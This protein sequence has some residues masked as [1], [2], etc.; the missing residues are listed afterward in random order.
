MRADTRI[1]AWED[2]GD[3]TA[4]L[5]LETSPF[6]AEGGGQVSDIGEI[7]GAGGRAAVVD[8]FRLGSDQVLRARLTEGVLGAGSEVVATVDVPRRRQIQANHTATHVLNWALRGT[9]GDGV[10]QAGSYVGPDKLRFDFTHRGRVE[11]EQLER[12]EAMVNGRVAEDQ[13]VQ[14]EVVPRQ[15][16]TDRGAIGL[17]E[18]KYGEFVRVV[19]T[20][21]FSKEL[22]GGTHVSSTGEIG[23][24][25]IVSEASTGAGARRIEALTGIAA[26]EY[27][28]GRE[29]ALSAEI[30]AATS[31][32]ASCRPS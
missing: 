7:A 3:G 21:D 25:V 9:L 1:T 16:A 11:P 31:G 32:S 19:S 6:Y 22:C 17:F 2:L 30:A 29:R 23:P 14:W 27:L 10:R 24:F 20:G 26:V 4:L 28:R 13:P 18:E 12:I 15:E 5:K 8:A